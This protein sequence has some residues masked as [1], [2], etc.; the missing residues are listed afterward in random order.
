MSVLI[1][2]IV[3]P[4]VDTC[5]SHVVLYLRCRD[6]KVPDPPEGHKWKEV[7]HDNTVRMQGQ[8]CFCLW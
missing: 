4:L 2:R 7:R 5:R 1:R 3:M 8:L 6:A